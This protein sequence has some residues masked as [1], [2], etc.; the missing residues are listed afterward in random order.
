VSN[1][2]NRAER[3]HQ[4]ER[5]KQKAKRRIAARWSHDPC[6]RDAALDDEESVGIE[7]NTPHQCSGPCCGNQ[8]KYWGPTHKELAAE[9]DAQDQINDFISEREQAWLD[10][11][12]DADHDEYSWELDE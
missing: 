12:A 11:L 5:A 4:A 1:R 10:E 6:E 2:R 8:R 3:R 7:A 9:A